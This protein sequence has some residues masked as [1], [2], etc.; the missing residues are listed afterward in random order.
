MV[1]T[2][3]LAALG[4]SVAATLPGWTQSA[5]E[6]V[7]VSRM[8]SDGKPTDV[9]TTYKGTSSRIEMKSGPSAGQGYQLFD[10]AKGSMTT[11]VPSQKMYMVL[12][13]AGMAGPA[14]DNAAAH[15]DKAPKITATGKTETI[16]GHT[17]EH[18]LIATDDGE[19]DI[20]AAKSL[21]FMGFMG[22]NPMARGRGPAPASV[23]IEHRALYESFKDGFQPLKMERINKGKRELMME[24][25]A[26]EKTSVPASTFAIPDGY[27][28]MD[29][30]G[31]MKD[32]MRGRPPRPPR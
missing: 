7:I 12:D 6:G 9:S 28:K 11:V 17:C 19:M 5:F 32:A 26:I 16:A 10:G 4:L 15:A 21:G 14:M 3:L 31:M 8:Y 25:V 13:I 24:V 20:C 23:P 18:Y 27:R 22:G 2:A 1:R 29:M 30:G